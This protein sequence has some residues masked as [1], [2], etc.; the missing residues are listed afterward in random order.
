MIRNLLVVFCL[1]ICFLI[2]GAGV[3][4]YLNNNGDKPFLRANAADLAGRWRNQSSS[5]HLKTEGATL[6]VDGADYIRDGKSPRWVEKAPKFQV[7]RVLD[8][9]GKTLT[10]TTVDDNGQRRSEVFQ[11]AQ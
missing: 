2:G 10:L 7:P 5:L 6:K 11:K 3:Y 1:L 9:D 4:R 8:W